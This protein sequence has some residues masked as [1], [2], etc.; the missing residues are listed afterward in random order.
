VA[1]AE[2]SQITGSL[3]VFALLVLP[4]ATAEALTTRPI[5]SLGIA[6]LIGLLVT[7]FGLGLSYYNDYPIGFH[8]TT[9]AFAAYV[10]AKGWQL[11]ESLLPGLVRRLA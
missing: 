3:L 6:V 2:A 10:L 8:I 1:T 5:A 4:P 9:L 7:W 11:R